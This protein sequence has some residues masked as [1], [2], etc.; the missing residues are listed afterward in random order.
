VEKTIAGDRRKIQGR[1]LKPIH[2]DI[3]SS[4]ALNEVAVRHSAT[5][6]IHSESFPLSVPR[7]CT[8]SPAKGRMP[9]EATSELKTDPRA[10]SNHVK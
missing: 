7:V 2:K 6:S 4:E 8:S 9:K 5:L 1:I 3:V 10:K